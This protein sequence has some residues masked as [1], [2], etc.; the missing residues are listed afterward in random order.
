MDLYAF[1]NQVQT[2]EEKEIIVS[3]RFRDRDGNVIPF[4]IRSLS[5]NELDDIVRRTSKVKMI[6]GLRV[7]SVDPLEVS[8]RIVVAATIQPPFDDKTLCDHYGV[9][10]PVSVPG[11]MLRPGE[12]NKL[13]DAISALSGYDED[14]I[15]RTE[16]DVKNS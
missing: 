5:Q 3:D 14:A 12:F 10:D 8:N 7:E 16:E 15:E 13:L 9:L 2:E 1:L 11:K 6:K 4:K